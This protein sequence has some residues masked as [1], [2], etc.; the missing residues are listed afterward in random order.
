MVIIRT[1]GRVDLN[2]S[3]RSLFRLM[4]P[5][6]H[7]PRTIYNSLKESFVDTS[8]GVFYHANLG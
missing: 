6:V 2:R 3:H 4:L 1:A 5:A 7:E 8:N